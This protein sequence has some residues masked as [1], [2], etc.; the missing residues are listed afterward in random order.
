MSDDVGLS[1]SQFGDAWRLLCGANPGHVI[2]GQKHIDYVFSRLPI[3]F[4]NIALI[5]ARDISRDALQMLGRD[6][7]TWAAG[8]EAPWMLIV[9]HDA[10][11]SGVDAAAAL[12]ATG[13][14]PLIPMTGMR[15][16]RLAAKTR[17]TNGLAVEVP[18][19]DAACE[20]IFD[21]NSAAYG[22]PLDACKATFGKRSFWTN[23]VP[24]IGRSYGEPVAAAAVFMVGGHRYVAMVA[25]LPNQ[26]R[27][28]Y[29]E[30][31][32]RHALDVMAA[33]HGE[34]PTTLH[35]T[36]AGRPVYVRMGY[37]PIA[38]HTAFIERRFLEGH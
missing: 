4:F 24:A 1:I 28:G 21:V 10:L 25:T 9:T 5:T 34:T 19:D 16:R 33:T 27:R 13:L 30:A 26:Q 11:K 12:E 3:P 8:K 32:M 29:A 14:V 15:A 20:A 38:S 35:A 18:A 7:V 22:M 36:E 31:V 37:E 2:E 23:H 6:A 17:N